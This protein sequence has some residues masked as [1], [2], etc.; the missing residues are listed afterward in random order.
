MLTS[1]AQGLLPPLAPLLLPP[2]PLTFC[3]RFNTSLGS[4]GSRATRAA[5]CGLTGDPGDA[6]ACDS[7]ADDL[8][9]ARAGPPVARWVSVALA[10]CCSCWICC[11]CR[12][13]GHDPMPPD[14]E[15]VGAAPGGASTIPTTGVGAGAPRCMCG[16]LPVRVP[17]TSPL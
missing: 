11:C 2:T 3:M 6:G 1:E 8:G 14:V 10:R 16:S 12:G 15:V 5:A 7:T 9:S 17:I 13:E 4:A